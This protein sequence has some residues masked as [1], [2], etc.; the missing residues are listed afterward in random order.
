MKD[1]IVVFV[2]S[3][4]GKHAGSGDV[5]VLM[6]VKIVFPSSGGQA[7]RKLFLAPCPFWRNS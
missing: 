5:Q 4:R 1:M 6:A 7:P 3:L 2:A